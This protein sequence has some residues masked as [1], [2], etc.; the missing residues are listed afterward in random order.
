V[1]NAA[2]DSSG[3]AWTRTVT[4]R[5]ASQGSWN[6]SFT[7]TSGDA[8]VD[9]SPSS[10]TLAPGASQTLTITAT[11]SQTDVDNFAFGNIVLHEASGASPDQHL[12]VAV[13]PA[14]LPPPP[15]L[16]NAGACV[17][18][19][20]NHQDSDANVNAVGAG[21]GTYFVYLNRFTP[22]PTDYPFTLTNVQ[23]VFV[24]ALSNGGVGAVVGELFDVYVYQDDDNDPSNGATL[25]AAVHDIAV[26]DPLGALQTITLPN[27]GVELDGPG[28][29]LVALEYH[30]ATGG[31][32]ATADASG[33]YQARSWIGAVHQDGAHGVNAPAGTDEI[34]AD[35]FDGATG[36]TG[37]D[38]A[39]EQMALISDVIAGFE[40]NFIVRGNGVKQNG[41]PVNVGS[42]SK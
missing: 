31:S 29:V 28:D 41:Q 14:G 23:T 26:A 25:V 10:F 13:K 42:A 32:P 33:T 17:L 37:P 8:S 3:C 35:G 18:K 5:L 39:N 7:P 40:Q 2:C 21:P 12:T 38:L 34:F 36:P 1:R 24:G 30:G 20:D 11:P 22:D 15:T 4:N 16:C 27:G 6:A 19:I 9:V